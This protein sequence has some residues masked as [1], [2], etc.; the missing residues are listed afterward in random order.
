MITC[1]FASPY[2]D[3]YENGLPASRRLRTMAVFVTLLLYIYGNGYVSPEFDALTGPG[4]PIQTD[5][6]K[7]FFSTSNNPRF[8]HLYAVYQLRLDIL[9]VFKLL[10]SYMLQTI[11]R[12]N[13][14]TKPM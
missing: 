11:M 10:K 3:L 2:Y 8:P 5:A 1:K 7:S 14:N 13:D 9:N 12:N 4:Y 6:E